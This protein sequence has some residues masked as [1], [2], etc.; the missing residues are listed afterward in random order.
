VHT[1]LVYWRIKP[2]KEQDFL[3]WWR[4]SISP[5]NWPRGLLE[6]RL[7][8]VVEDETNSWDISHPGAIVY[9]NVGRWVSKSYFHDWFKTLPTEPAPF[10]VKLRQRIWLELKEAH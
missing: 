8:K 2:T 7:S 3:K 5:E 6:E 10:E 1:V 9:V 4:E